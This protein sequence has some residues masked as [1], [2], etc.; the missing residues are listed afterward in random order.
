MVKRY[1]DSRVWAEA[2]IDLI[3]HEFD[4]LL[5]QGHPF[6]GKIDRVDAPETR[7]GIARRRIVDY[8]TGR[9]KLREQMYF[10]DKLQLA[11][12]REAAA[13]R[14]GG[15]D[16]DLEFHFLQDGSVVRLDLSENDISRTL[17][18]AGM[19]ANEIHEAVRTRQFPAKATAWTCPTCPYRAVCDEGRAAMEAATATVLVEAPARRATDMEIPF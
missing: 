6:D 9:P 2:Q 16:F 17:Y 15:K 13:R 7:D 5:V 19:T 11:L 18:A 3:E 8:K 1:G 12:Y 4:S 10:D 14:T